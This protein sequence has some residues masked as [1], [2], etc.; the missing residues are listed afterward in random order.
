MGFSR[1]L[2]TKLRLEGR[3]RDAF[4]FG[5]GLALNSCAFVAEVAAPVNVYPGIAVRV[6][7]DIT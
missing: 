2:P 7:G 3:H 4:N 5:R 6:P 1:L